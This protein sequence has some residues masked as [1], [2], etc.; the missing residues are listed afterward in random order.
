MASKAQ[1]D[2]LTFG[3]FLIVVVIG[4][5][6]WQPLQVIDYW[7]IFRFV[8]FVGGCWVVVLAGMQSRNTMKYAMGAFVLVAWG[9]IL[10]AI[11][12]AW[13]LYSYTYVYAYSVVVFLLAFAAIAIAAALRRK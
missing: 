9:V 11:G 13:F 2:L 8:I 4:I 3:V 1:R 7:L 12:G 6:L 5:L 10:I